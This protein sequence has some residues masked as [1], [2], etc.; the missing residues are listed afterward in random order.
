MSVEPTVTD[1]NL[2]LVP[3]PSPDSGLTTVNAVEIAAILHEPVVAGSGGEALRAVSAR[4]QLSVVLQSPAA[5]VIDHNGAPPAR[6]EMVAAAVGLIKMFE[7]SKFSV[8]AYGWNVQ[9]VLNGVNPRETMSRLVDAQQL[10][11]VLGKREEAW[12]V[13]QITLST[14][15]GMAD[16]TRINV[17]LQVVVEPDGRESLRFDANAHYE[18]APDIGRLGDEGPRVW[19]SISEIIGRLPG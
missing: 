15:A 9:G 1:Y 7:A 17:V 14:D 18:R 5:A 4:D 6:L 3:Q 19:A 16:A 8:Q 10:A 11:D 2:T 13:S 12:S